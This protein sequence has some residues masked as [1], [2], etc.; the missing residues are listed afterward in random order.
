MNFRLNAWAMK[1][2]KINRAKIRA[3]IPS[4]RMVNQ[5]PFPT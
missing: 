1:G 2:E 3:A 5:W 4:K